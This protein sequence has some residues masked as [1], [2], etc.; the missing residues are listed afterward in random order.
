LYAAI[1]S[2]W[3]ATDATVKERVA[4]AKTERDIAQVAFDRSVTETRRDARITS[5][6]IA[7]FVDVMRTNVRTG[8]TPLRRAYIRFV[9]DQV[10]V[11]DTEIRIVG[12]RAVF[13]RLVMGGR[14]GGFGRSAQFCPEVARPKRLEL[15]T[16]R[17][18]RSLRG[19]FVRYM[20]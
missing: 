10:E 11:D 2:G 8:E 19:D 1:E 15:L 7:A 12:R 13:E 18:G 17:V 20:F 4:T 5:D 16:P 9:I 14:A 6:K 3:H